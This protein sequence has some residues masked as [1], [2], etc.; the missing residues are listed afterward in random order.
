MKVEV[1]LLT[2]EQG[3]VLYGAGVV[4]VT[5]GHGPQQRAVACRAGDERRIT[6]PDHAPEW[7]TERGLSPY[8]ARNLVADALEAEEKRR[9]REDEERL[10]S[11]EATITKRFCGG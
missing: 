8:T 7:L 6:T 11:P 1:D 10:N 4:Y 9:E 2:T 3:G 5:I